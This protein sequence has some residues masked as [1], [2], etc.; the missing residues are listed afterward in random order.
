MKSVPATELTANLDAVL[1]SAQR[2]RIIISR[3]GKPC[4]VLVGIEKYDAEDFQLATSEEFW[5]MIRE[6]RSSGK[7]YPLA[8]VEARLQFP[9]KKQ[10]RKS[11]TKKQV[12]HG[13]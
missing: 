3:R 1:N 6:R 13:S 10:P 2:E 4:A 11:R 7:S 5:N 12:R 8:E 9:T